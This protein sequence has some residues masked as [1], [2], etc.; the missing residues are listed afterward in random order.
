MRRRDRGIATERQCGYG[1]RAAGL[2]RK[3]NAVAA[4][5]QR[6]FNGRPTTFNSSVSVCDWKMVILQ[7]LSFIYDI[8]KIQDIIMEKTQDIATKKTKI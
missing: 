5:R 6:D 2:W 8:E 3:G 1:A 7:T 4:G